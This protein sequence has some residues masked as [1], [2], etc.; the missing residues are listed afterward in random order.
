MRGYSYRAKRDTKIGSSG[1]LVALSRVFMAF[2]F[3]FGSSEGKITFY[4]KVSHELT[5]NQSLSLL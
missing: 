2:N 3:V 5:C 1:W 4:S